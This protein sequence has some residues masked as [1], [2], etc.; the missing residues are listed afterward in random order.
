ME[1]EN[2][3]EIQDNN[4]NVQDNK[5][6]LHDDSIKQQEERK[7]QIYAIFQQLQEKNTLEDI[8]K[9]TH[10]ALFKLEA[11]FNCDY[12][13]FDRTI[14][15]GFIRIL[16]REYHI[17]LEIWIKD[18]DEYCQTH[19]LFK[20]DEYDT[21]SVGDVSVKIDRY[22]KRASSKWLNIAIAVIVIIVG[23][24]Y[25]FSQYYE[26]SPLPNADTYK[27]TDNSTDIDD[28]T[29]NTDTANNETVDTEDN[30]TTIEE[31]VENNQTQENNTTQEVALIDEEIVFSVDDAV[32]G[33]QLWL[34]VLRVE[35]KKRTQHIVVGSLN[36]KGGEPT[37]FVTGHGKF[38]VKINGQDDSL[39]LNGSSPVYL[40]Y[41]PG[42]Q[43]RVVTDSEFKKI[44]NGRG[45]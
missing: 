27:N 40:Y 16:E 30:A 45:W 34:G 43:I 39:R 12:E 3:Q 25:L 8:H 9:K 41:N 17:D 36:I 29:N 2:K 7:Q 20:R 26:D 6:E 5:N 14:A 24:W 33:K 23:G 19:G 1:D 18:Y 21:H 13:Q 42:E 31:N 37:L 22:E 38:N 32:S 44:N 11:I 35:S 4:D 28:D 15:I 10:I